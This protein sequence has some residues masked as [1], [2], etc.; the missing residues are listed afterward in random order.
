MV[1]KIKQLVEARTGGTA[2]QYKNMPCPTSSEL[3]TGVQIYTTGYYHP[4]YGTDRKSL[5]M[6]HMSCSCP[7]SVGI[8]NQE[9][10]DDIFPNNK[11]Y[12]PCNYIPPNIPYCNKT[13]SPGNPPPHLGVP[14]TVA[15]PDCIDFGTRL[16]IEGKNY[17][18]E[19]RG[20]DIQG[21]RIDIWSGKSIDTAN[22]NSGLAEIKRGV[23]K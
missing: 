17:I 21:K 13:A 2:E 11:N 18:V 14:T 10:C 20:G 1:E 23:C 5:C 4:P 8:N 9:N 15:A 22:S 6:I 16:C 19:D 3:S 7:E 12:H